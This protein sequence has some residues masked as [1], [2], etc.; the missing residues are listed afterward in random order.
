M[1]SISTIQL[2]SSILSLIQFKMA[3]AVISIAHIQYDAQRSNLN[4][5]EWARFR[6]ELT[7]LMIDNPGM[8]YLYIFCAILQCENKAVDV[9]FSKRVKV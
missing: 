2:I 9:L 5:H 1:P 8:I 3:D 4:K 6:N 7:I